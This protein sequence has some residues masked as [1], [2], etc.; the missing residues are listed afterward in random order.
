MD[1]ERAIGTA[2]GRV[3]R[4]HDVTVVTMATEALALLAA[5]RHFDVILSDVVMPAMSGMAFYDELTR[6]FPDVADRV[7]FIS[8][9]S[10]TLESRAFFDRVLNPRIDKPFDP[11]TVREAVGRFVT[12]GLPANRRTDSRPE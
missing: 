4:D 12:S 2:L 11:R 10:V 8:G 9:G 7:I 3:L 1:D 5:G 6:R